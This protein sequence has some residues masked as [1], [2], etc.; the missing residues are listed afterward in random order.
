MR[1]L[2]Y[3]R[4]THIVLSS[5]AWG[6]RYPDALAAFLK[7]EGRAKIVCFTEDSSYTVFQIVRP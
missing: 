4:I 7:D 3:L 1:T 6:I 2:D 5:R